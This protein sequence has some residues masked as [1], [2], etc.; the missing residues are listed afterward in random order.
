VTMLMVV[1]VAVVVVVVVVV[2]V[3]V[4]GAMRFQHNNIAG[5]GC[6]VHLLPQ[7]ST[8]SAVSRRPHDPSHQRTK[9]E[10]S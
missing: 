5:G 1:V 8:H 10:H 9:F 7:A 4:E 3:V 2:E 6:V